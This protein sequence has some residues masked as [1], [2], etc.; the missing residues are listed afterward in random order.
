[1]DYALVKD[2]TK[3]CDC[4]F[5]H[6][7]MSSSPMFVDYPRRGIEVNVIGFMN[8]M[9]S[10]KRNNIRKVVYASSSSLYNGLT[11]PFK[12]SANIRPKTFYE[13]SFFCRETIAHTYNLEY[14][15]DSVGLRYFSVYGPQEKHKGKFANTISQFI[16]SM[17]EEKKSPIIYGDGG[18]TRDFTY[19]EDVVQANLLAMNKEKGQQ[20][21]PDNIADVENNDS[22][23]KRKRKWRNNRSHG[24]NIYNIGTGT[25]T[26]FNTLVEILN[27]KFGTDIKP[28]Y[29]KNPI[30]HYV[31]NTVAD[32]SLARQE[33]GY[34]PKW[35]NAESGIAQLLKL[36]SELQA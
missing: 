6:G 2:L 33:L 18:Q 25:Q 16:W 24:F 21:G 35:K 23:Y 20:L 11:P 1:M 34:E 29:I 3:D 4:I 26:S 22:N 7:A 12:E 8:I 15:V 27:K 10:A 31:Q 19:V 14:G 17:T 30:R 5:H 32:I 28:T 13:S 9:E 36:T